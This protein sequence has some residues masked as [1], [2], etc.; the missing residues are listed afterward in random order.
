[1]LKSVVFIVFFLCLRLPVQSGG[2]DNFPV[3]ENAFKLKPLIFADFF[4]PN[5]DG[6]N[7]T[8]VIQNIEEYPINKL[9]VFNRWGEIVYTSEPYQNDWDGT[10]NIKADLF[11]DILPEGMYF[12]RFEFLV[13]DYLTYANGK[14]ILKR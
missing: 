8:F 9:F 3:Q 1:M 11:G 13:G 12:Y 4:S 2:L 10:M 6:H 7:D 5:G 14:I